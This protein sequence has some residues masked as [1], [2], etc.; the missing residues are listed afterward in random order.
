MA[1]MELASD[2]STPS[3][4][5]IPTS[6]W[7]GM[8]L[9][10][11]AAKHVPLVHLRQFRQVRNCLGMTRNTTTLVY[12]RQFGQVWSTH[13][14][15]PEFRSS[16]TCINLGKY[17]TMERDLKLAPTSYICVNLGRYETPFG[18]V[19]GFLLSYTCFNLGRYGT[20]N[21]RYTRLPVKTLFCTYQNLTLASCFF[22]RCHIN[23]GLTYTSQA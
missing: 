23:H 18:S 12:L 11:D 3:A 2:V 7:T 8:E 16:Y 1:G 22:V 17:E 5:R 19:T 9:V 20:I 14:R 13:A 4:S 15:P 21:T 6:I 10:A